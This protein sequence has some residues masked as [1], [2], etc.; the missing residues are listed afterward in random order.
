MKIHDMKLQ[1]IEE[2]S[3]PNI[4]ELGVAYLTP[5]MI[6]WL[7]CPC[8]CDKSVMLPIRIDGAMN[9][10]AARMGY[11]N[12]WTMGSEEPLSLSPSVWTKQHPC[13]SHY[14]ITG[15]KVQWC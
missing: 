12:A 5:R 7:L 14:F 15:G 13:Q 8:G 4:M 3:M 9:P 11:I 6:M 10:T 2:N 1:R